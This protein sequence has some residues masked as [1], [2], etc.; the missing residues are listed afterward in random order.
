MPSRARCTGLPGGIP[1]HGAIAGG[2]PV[3]PLA[4][5]AGGGSGRVVGTECKH[6]ER[7]PGAALRAQGRGAG[8]GF[9][10]RTAPCRLDQSQRYVDG[11]LQLAGEVEARRGKVADRAWRG[12]LPRNRRGE[13]G[14]GRHGRGLGHGQQADRRLRGSGHLAVRIKRASHRKL[15]VRLPGAQPDIAQQHVAHDPGGLPCAHRHFMRPADRDRAQGCLPVAVAIGACAEQLPGECDG[16]RDTGRCIA[17][18]RNRPVALQDRVVLEQRMQQRHRGFLRPCAGAPAAQ[19]Q[20][21]HGAQPRSA[22]HRPS[23]GAD[24]NCRAWYQASGCGGAASPA[25]NGRPLTDWK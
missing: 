23:P 24:G 11:L 5:P 6:V 19:G 9:D 17:P 4:A 3:L 7:T 8:P 15:H 22:A 12:G 20:A 25:G 10:P 16:H 1:R 18:H 13:G 21:Q 2:P 14:L